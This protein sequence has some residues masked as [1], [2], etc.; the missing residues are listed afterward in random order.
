[1]NNRSTGN[2]ITGLILGAVIGL[3]AGMLYAPQPGS[4]TRELLKEKAEKVKE[5]AKEVAQK[6]RHTTEEITKKTPE[7][8]D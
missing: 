2:F 7:S 5:K 8:L 4:E 6:V 3:A 1:M